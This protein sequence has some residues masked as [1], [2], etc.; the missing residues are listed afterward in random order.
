MRTAK[1]IK[2]RLDAERAKTTVAILLNEENALKHLK[3]EC[4]NVLQ[5]LDFKM[6]EA[7]E[8]IHDRR[9]VDHISTPCMIPAL[10]ARVKLALN[11]LGYTAVSHVVCDGRMIRMDVKLP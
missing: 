5:D 2:E 9:P 10:A 7:Q 4:R 11:R 6:L 1:V 8:A 3:R